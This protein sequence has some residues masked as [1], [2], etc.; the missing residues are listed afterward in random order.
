MK[1]KLTIFEKLLF[2]FNVIAG[3]FLVLIYLIPYLSPNHFPWI[4]LLSLGYPLLVIVNLVFFLI[5]LIRL[6]PHF[7]FSAILIGIGYKDL[8]SFYSL[9]AKENLK[10][11]DIKL[12]SYNVRY[13]NQGNWIKSPT[14][15]KETFQFIN[16]KKVD[17]ACIQE[18]RD[19]KKHQIKLPFSYKKRHKGNE[20][21]IYSRYPIVDK[22]SL[23]FKNTLNNV[24]YSDL[25]IGKEIIRVYNVHMQSFGLKTDKEHYGDKNNKELLKHFKKVFIKQSEQILILKKHIKTCPYRTIIAGD[26]NNTAFSWNYHQLISDRKDAF[27]EAGSGFGATYNYMLP[28]RIDFILPQKDMNVASF[29]N[30]NVKLSDHYPILARIDL[31][32]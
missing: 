4:N 6:K 1:K 28:L 20:Q 7:L 5:W 2:F 30:F 16:S 11:S 19:V 27:V 14:I 24:I 25:K 9:H 17:I 29:T 32:N 18:H 31:N 13:F 15:T 12:L 3:L 21:A 23:E 10:Q 8:T 22:G 26:F